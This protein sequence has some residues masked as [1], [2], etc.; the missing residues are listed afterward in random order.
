M[1]LSEL[2]LVAEQDLHQVLFSD[3]L[4]VQQAATMLGVSAATLRN[5]DRSGKLRA[6]RHPLNGYRLYLKA[7]LAKLLQDLARGGSQDAA[8]AD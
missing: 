2:V 3:Y 1:V 7:D 6:T 5:W 8:L 4:T